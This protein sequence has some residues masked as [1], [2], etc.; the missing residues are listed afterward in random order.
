[1]VVV[2]VVVVVVGESI[3]LTLVNTSMA[4]SMPIIRVSL[5]YYN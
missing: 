2:V 3:I 5:V 4:N 1:M